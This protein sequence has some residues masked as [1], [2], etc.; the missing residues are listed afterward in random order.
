MREFLTERIKTEYISSGAQIFIAEVAKALCY[1]FATILGIIGAQRN[2]APNF[3]IPEKI[4]SGLFIGIAIWG[5][6]A[7]I[8]ISTVTMK[9]SSPIIGRT[10]L[11]WVLISFLACT[12]IPIIYFLQQYWK[13]LFLKWTNLIQTSL[14]SALSFGLGGVI[15][16]LT[17]I[18]LQIF[19]WR[20][21]RGLRWGITLTCALGVFLG[22]GAG[23]AAY[24]WTVFSSQVLFS[25]KFPL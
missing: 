21:L 15:I 17:A 3:P 5:A 13:I 4:V 7:G 19:F 14:F 12:T 10:A 23:W 6:L 2:A 1:A 16:G 18:L 22:L 8:S 24:G 20:L 11:R 9:R 25:L